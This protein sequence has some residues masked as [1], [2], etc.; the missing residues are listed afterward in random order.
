MYDFY[1]YPTLQDVHPE[2]PWWRMIVEQTPPG[3]TPLVWFWRRTDY[4]K[5]RSGVGVDDQRLLAEYDEKRPLLAPGPFCGQVWVWP[6]AEATTERDHL[7]R[8]DRL[9]LG[10]DTGHK[11]HQVLF[12]GC[13]WQYMEQGAMSQAEYRKLRSA[14]LAKPRPVGMGLMGRPP[15]QW[16]P[17]GAVLVAGPGSPWAPPA[18]ETT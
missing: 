12:P 15:A 4:A 16:P 1:G 7:P 8:V 13:K 9:V 17:E 6:E 2:L 10:V 11:G 5:V 18:K 3:G 14:F